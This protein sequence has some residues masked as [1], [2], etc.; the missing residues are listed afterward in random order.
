M[1]AVAAL[2]MSGE[3]AE[4]TEPPHVFIDRLRHACD[5]GPID[6]EDLR[7]LPTPPIGDD[8]DLWQEGAPH[9]EDR[10]VRDKE[11]ISVGA[12]ERFY[13]TPSRISGG[14]PDVHVGSRVPNIGDDRELAAVNAAYETMCDETQLPDDF[15]AA[16]SMAM[17]AIGAFR[18]E[19]GEP[20]MLDALEKAQLERIRYEGFVDGWVA[21][22]GLMTY[23]ECEACDLDSAQC[24]AEEAWRLA[25][26][27]IP[28]VLLLPRAGH[29]LQPRLHA[30]HR[31]VHQG[32]A[33]G[34]VSSTDN[35]DGPMTSESTPR[36]WTLNFQN[37]Q[38]F[39]LPKGRTFERVEVIEK[40]PVLDLL[41]AARSSLL[42]FEYGKI[43]DDATNLATQRYQALLVEI[44]ALLRACG[45]PVGG[46][47][48]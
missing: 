30:R 22:S 1:T 13:T 31:Q 29:D 23:E 17:T 9:S 40:D 4:P 8:F 12:G 34:R 35:G 3:P 44:N 46:E 32:I 16:Q 33:G 28:P 42:D 48:A 11:S 7:C 5:L 15:D 47:T 36:T 27:D 18:A 14:S 25:Y 21:E 6:G 41:M 20:Q 38:F 19:S 24:D 26:G 39:P 10:L 43:E 45:R 37:G 2:S